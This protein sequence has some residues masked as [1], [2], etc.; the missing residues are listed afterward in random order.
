[1]IGRSHVLRHVDHIVNMHYERRRNAM[2]LDATQGL[3]HIVTCL[4]SLTPFLPSLFSL[5]VPPSPSL[6]LPSVEELL[7]SSVASDVYREAPLTRKANMF[8]TNLTFLGPLGSGKTSLLRSF[9]GQT[10]RL[11]EPSTLS[12]LFSDSYFTL[13]DHSNWSSSSAPLMYED[14]LIRIIIDELLKQAHHLLSAERKLNE[15]QRGLAG[16]GGADGDAP[17]PISSLASIQKRSQSFSDVQGMIH[18]SAHDVVAVKASN[19]FSGSYEV[20]DSDRGKLQLG[21][22]TDSDS[23]RGPPLPPERRH[24]G[25]RHTHRRNFISRFFTG[26]AKTKSGSSLQRHYSDSLK[27]SLY[28]GIS[29]SNGNVST[30]YFSSLPEPLI[31][32]IRSELAS[33][34]DSS[35]PP[36]YF[37]KLIDM[38]GGRA[39]QALRSLFITDYSVCVL[40]YDA[41][42]NLDS[43]VLPGPRRKL[44]AGSSE[45]KANGIVPGGV[46]HDTY[47]NHVMS[48]FNNLCLHWSHSEA[49]MTVRGPRIILVGTHSDKVPSSVSHNNFD[50][51]RRA[52]QSS[53]YQKYVAMMKYVLSSSSLIERANMDDLKRFTIEVVKKSCRQQVPLKWLRCVRRFFGL[54][55][56]G[57]YFISLEDARKIVVDMCDL[58][59]EEHVDDVIA[60]LRNNQVILHFSGVY[61]LRTIVFTNP[62]WFAQQLGTLFGAAWTTELNPST[63]PR[64]KTDINLLQT[65]GIVTKH[66]LEH[67]WRDRFVAGCR[68]KLLAI[69]HKMDL[70]C[71]LGSNSQPMAPSLS[72]SSITQD[73]NGTAT[74]DTPSA[75][76]VS[77][78]IIPSVLTEPV[79]SHLSKL[80]TFMLEP[81]LFVFKNGFVPFGVFPRLIVRCIHSYP[82]RYTL[83]SNGALFEVDESTLLLVLEKKDHIT[84]SLHRSLPPPS[85]SSSSS[86]GHVPSDLDEIVASY[87]EPPNLDTCMAIQ[88]FLQAGISDIVQQ[89]LPQVDY[90]LCIECK[91]MNNSLGVEGGGGSGSATHYIILSQTDD[92]LQRVSLDCENGSQVVIGPT[93]YSWFGEIPKPQSPT[94]DNAGKEEGENEWYEIDNLNYLKRH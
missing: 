79:P 54:S 75:L 83:Y 67:V 63:L 62:S 89:W 18:S 46:P 12:L 91:C 8:V 90:H 40:I 93:L 9:L 31:H 38:P 45:G 7:R 27:H 42:K 33:L 68:D 6:P 1:M 60:F 78:I 14:E 64:V 3:R 50:R 94:E 26:K 32:K 48:E 80:P 41:S 21:Y 28:T 55:S 58:T 20:M 66:L 49:D 51:L 85:T 5:P 16:V 69:L 56:R 82:H 88:M 19:R 77:S 17:S 44:S 24:S 15:P 53:P 37:G 86:L 39:F 43:S 35:L 81:L 76:S 57:I 74:S 13:V 34:T 92:V 25:S 23:D 2:Q 61:Q 59:P 47:F 30:T 73:V 10:F 36:K 71:C 72:P 84:V 11:A 29:Q 4:N 70:I 65:H 22:G 52:I 87:P